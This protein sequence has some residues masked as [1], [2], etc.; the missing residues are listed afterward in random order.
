MYYD[1]VNATN[2][3]TLRTT[4]HAVIDD[5][6]RFPYT[7]GNTDTWDILELTDEQPNDAD[8]VLDVSKNASILKFGGGNGHPHT[9][10]RKQKNSRNPLRLPAAVFA[11][12]YG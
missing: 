5:H 1:P 8:S 10:G 2:S 6:T 12:L 4:L 3:A 11:Y 9:L 7:S